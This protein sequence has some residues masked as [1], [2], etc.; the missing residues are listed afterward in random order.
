MDL[1]FWRDLSLVLLTAEVFVACLP[2]LIIFYITIKGMIW[3]KAKAGHYLLLIRGKV[4]G[5]ERRA[6]KVSAILG[7]PVIRGY[8]LAAGLCGGAGRLVSM[9]RGRGRWKEGSKV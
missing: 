5:T 2:I 7:F 9:V 3:L 8:A 6:K 1:P 4:E